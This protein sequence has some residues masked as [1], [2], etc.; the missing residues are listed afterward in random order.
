VS[1]L[2]PESFYRRDVLEVAPELIGKLFRR[3]SVILRITEV[4][5]Y[6]DDDSACHARF[7]VTERTKPLFGPPGRAYVYLCYGLHYML[8]VVA[9]LPG[10]AGAVLIR[11]A[12]PAA[13][14]LTIQRRRSK[15]GERGPVLLTGPGKVGA[16]LG[17]DL[18]F[19]HHPLFEGGGL[20][21]LEGEAPAKL[22]VGLRVGIDYANDRDRLAPWRWAAGDTAWVSVRK[23]LR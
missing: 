19:N 13:G 14:L 22:V 8:N 5:A 18:R 16:A 7:G 3:G 2:V 11:S 1:E 6:R 4:E 20:E 21:L 10:K 17:L 9:H 12:E 23:S 15:K